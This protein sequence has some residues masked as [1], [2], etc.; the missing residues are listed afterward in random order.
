MMSYRS[1]SQRFLGPDSDAVFHAIRVGIV[2][3]SGGGSHVVQQ[4][5]HLGV[6][7]FT[8]ADH[9]LIEEKNLNRL[10]GA[11]AADVAANMPKTS[12]AERVIKNVNPTA[13]VITC[14]C[15][16]QQAVHHLRACDIVFGC[17][18]SFKERSELEGF[19]RRFLM[20]Y[21]DIGMDIHKSS[22]G[23]RMGGQ[24][25][26]S[27]P[28]GPC[29]RCFGILSERRLAEEARQYG[30]G[31]SAPQVVWPNGVLASIG[32]GLFVQLV[33]SW[34]DEPVAT[35]CAEFDGNTHVVEASRMAYASELRCQHFPGT[36]VGDP[37]FD[38]GG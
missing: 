29:L 21:I 14:L 22:Q 10:V 2:G 12:I 25:V 15:R 17:V 24:V 8:V 34:H 18:D 1:V 28:G 4:L 38:R 19:C 11:T 36:E 23:F 13:E 30:Q 32:V 7:H 3:L 9:D 37:F 20:P 33:T 6:L 5:A 26:L 35:Y 31:G 16:W 27:S